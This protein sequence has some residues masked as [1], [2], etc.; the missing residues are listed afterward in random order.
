[1]AY[2]KF[3]TSAKIYLWSV[4]IGGL[5]NG[6]YLFL[7][8]PWHATHIVPLLVF[9]VMIL[10]AQSRQIQLQGF[11]STKWALTLSTAFVFAAFFI[12]SPGE[13]ALLLLLMNVSDWILTPRH[14]YTKVFNLGQF[15]V[16]LTL[17]LLIWNLL[18]PSSELIAP[19]IQALV[20]ACLTV[21]LFVALNSFLVSVLVFL[22]HRQSL[23]KAGI[24]TAAFVVNETVCLS[25]GIGMAALWH[26]YPPLI[27][28]IVLPMGVLFLALAKIQQ[29]EVEI[30]SERE[31]L[32]VRKPG[33][34]MGAELDMGKLSIAIVEIVSEVVH[35]CGTILM[36]TDKESKSF[37][38][39]AHCKVESGVDI[40]ATLPME[41]LAAALAGKDEGLTLNNFALHRENYPEL[42]F[43]EAKNVILFPLR[44]KETLKGVLIIL[45]DGGR[46]EF[47]NRDLRLLTNLHDYIIM[48]LQN[49]QLYAQVKN[50]QEQLLHSEKLSALGQLISG[51]A[52]ELNNP[53]A[54]IIGFGQLSL[55]E[56]ELRPKVR[57]RLQ[58]IIREGERTKHIVENL[59]SFARRRETERVEIDI[60]TILTETISL[61]EYDMNVNNV[62]IEKQLDP[63][64]P[65]TMA[66]PHQLQ[67]VFINI[68][69]N[70]YD[71]MYET[72]KKGRLLIVT[73]ATETT[74]VIEF[75]DNGP[76]MKDPTKVFDP[77]FTTKPVGK[78]TG[79]GLSIC[80][81]IIKDHGGEIYAQNNTPRGARFIIE[82]PICSIEAAETTAANEVVDSQTNG[83]HNHARILV[84]DDEPDLLNLEEQ[85]L[86]EEGYRVQ[87]AINGERA[88]EVLK[89]QDFDLI[90]SDLKMP[91]KVSGFDLYKWLEENRQGKEKNI[92]FITGDRVGSEATEFFE[93]YKIRYIGKP[94]NIDEYITIVQD[95][96]SHVV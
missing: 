90:I 87:T 74:I 61:R 34:E 68:I 21:I 37:K 45:G 44:V 2:A 7:R 64:L 11:L 85:L 19:S 13:V 17:S 35:A 46:R 81:G 83:H 54:T 12:F 20:A 75:I 28:F 80:Y 15:F 41:N 63:S 22:V 43:L 65:T 62:I 42:R 8:G 24:L 30:E 23:L 58:T 55:R 16:S 6:V 38:I 78:G 4:V 18:R 36:I 79:L 88:I 48:S 25:S 53:L 32:S 5:A 33:L 93:R 92:L 40:P 56:K 1:M 73:R 27:G 86:S 71:A 76:G 29:R 47:D 26:V 50:M 59:L 89:S 10:L 57:E 94:F 96:T 67:Q 31:V 82:L 9:T 60:N 39:L 70:G 3:G 84:V 49:A 66:D 52:H 91:G 95:L 77:F 14:W 69:N 72:H 51:V